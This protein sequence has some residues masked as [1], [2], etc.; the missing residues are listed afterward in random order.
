MR[1]AHTAEHTLATDGDGTCRR[2]AQGMSPRTE[3]WEE[4][5]H[6]GLTLWDCTQHAVSRTGLL[7]GAERRTE[8]PR[9]QG[10]TREL[11]LVGTELLPGLTEHFGNGVRMVYDNVDAVAPELGTY[12]G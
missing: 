8:P 3:P 10:G 11:L 2:Q 4:A 9:G 1:S 7:I 6:P 12:N 5:R